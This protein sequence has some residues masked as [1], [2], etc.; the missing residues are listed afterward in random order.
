MSLTETKIKNAKPI[1]K[2][3]LMPDER[4]L[5][6]E[7][8]AS[9]GKWWRL[10]YSFNRKQ[11]RI[12]LGTYPEIS[13]NEARA[14]RE[15]VRKQIA[16]HIDPCNHKK[17]QKI[18]NNANT[19]SFEVIAV[20]WFEKKSPAWAEGHSSKIIARLRNDV[21]PILGS[22]PIGQIMAPEL[23]WCLRKIEDRGANES[24]HRTL[25]IC[26]QIFRYAIVTGRLDR[27]PAMDLKGA[28]APVKKSHLPAIV[29]PVEVG[30]LM[31]AIKGYQGSVVTR[32]ALQLAPLVFVRPGELRQAEWVEINLDAAEWNIPAER[33]KMKEPHLVPLSRQAVAILKELKLY[34]GQ[35]KFVF[36]SERTHRRPISDNTI[37]ACLR[38]MGYSK[39]EMTGHGFRAMARTILDEVLNVRVE[40]IE[41]QLAHTVRDPLGRAYNRTKHLD[42]RRE[43]MQLWAN[44]LDDISKTDKK[45]M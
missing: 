43:M 33:M 26:G 41:H 2:N 5:Y 6:L 27:N 7:V 17:A 37:N 18:A 1:G 3:Y 25:Q 32:L 11:R 15:A 28:L 20:E 9:G 14:R 39:D 22:K 38:R 35:G 16:N 8:S 10:R 30:K 13:L 29:D 31:E 4:G 45:A 40:Y 24:A 36:P 42:E 12:S 44:Y 21:F 19:N 23:L 34:T